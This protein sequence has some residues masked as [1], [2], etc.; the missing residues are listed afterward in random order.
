MVAQTNTGYFIQH[1]ETLQ[2]S[3]NNLAALVEISEAT[4]GE[5]S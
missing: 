4:D 2:R 3:R 5:F 1:P